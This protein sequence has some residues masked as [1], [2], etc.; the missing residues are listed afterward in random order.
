MN[1][2]PNWRGARL[3]EEMIDGFGQEKAQKRDEDHDEKETVHAYAGPT[4]GP[5][6]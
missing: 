3:V 2:T 5:I 6:D 4:F 1:E